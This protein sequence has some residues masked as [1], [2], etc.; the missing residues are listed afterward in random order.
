MAEE[1]S[2]SHSLTSYCPSYTRWRRLPRHAARKQ[3]RSRELVTDALLPGYVFVEVAGMADL[4]EALSLDSVFGFISV[5]GDV[6]YARDADVE[7]IREAEASGI[8]N[9]KKRFRNN[10][11]KP[12]AAELLLEH[13]RQIFDASLCGASAEISDGPFKGKVG[14]VE[15]V[16]RKSGRALLSVNGLSIGADASMLRLV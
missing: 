5:A 9:A 6:C 15:S 2:T 8:H 13:I 1:L 3:G 10:E 14:A 11:R 4:R 12:T 7:E 16:D